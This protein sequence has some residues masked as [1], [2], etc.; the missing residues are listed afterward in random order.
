MP[1]RSEAELVVVI[2]VIEEAESPVVNVGGT[3]LRWPR[4]AGAPEL[5]PFSKYWERMFVQPQI[6][7]ID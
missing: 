1:E 4:L 3:G 2:E 6:T 5:C 7:H